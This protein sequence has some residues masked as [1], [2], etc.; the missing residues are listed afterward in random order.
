MFIKR[1][2]KFTYHTPS[3]IDEA[4]ELLVRYNGHAKVLAGGTDLLVAMK[5]R[6]VIPSHI[7]NLKTIPGLS[8]ITVT[9]EGVTIGSLTTVAEIEKS[10]LIKE[11]FKP[12]WD[13]AKVMAS[14]QIRTLATIGGNLV[15]AVPSADLAPPLMVMAATAHIKGPSGERV[16]PVDHLFAGPSTTALKPSEILTHITIP[17]QNGRG[18]YLKL[19]R[20][21]ALDLAIVGV[22]VS[23]TVKE[24]NICQDAKIG[25]G[26]VAP[27][28]IRAY[29]AE[30]EII[31]NMVTEEVAQ[32]VA[33]TASRE[34][35]PITD[36]RATEDYRRSMVRTL[37]KRAIMNLWEGNR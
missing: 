10:P 32:K 8:G 25:L 24:D 36:I 3:T 5:K 20:R 21:A 35:A 14:P 37:T 33:D 19:M 31:G 11:N 4:I 30:R 9:G 7:V 15:S 6:S 1:L 16:C 29:K 17:L 12:L 27:T 13:A 18:I 28:P 2:P 34:C 22:A 26:A 23:L